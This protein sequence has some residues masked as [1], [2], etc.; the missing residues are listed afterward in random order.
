LKSEKKIRRNA[1]TKKARSA[2][3]KKGGELSTVFIHY[4]KK[5]GRFKST[6]DDSG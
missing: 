4:S 1:T 6:K 2:P 5:M 3:I